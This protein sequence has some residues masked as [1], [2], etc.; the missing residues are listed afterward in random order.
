MITLEDLRIDNPVE[1]T[2]KQYSFLMS[3]F[4]G[5]VAGR[6]DEKTGAYYIKCWTI[7]HAP[8]ILKILHSIN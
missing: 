7:K 2:E 4:G 6:K 1:V 5:L 8:A 3:K